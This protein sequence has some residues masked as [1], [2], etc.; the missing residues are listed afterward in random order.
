MTTTTLSHKHLAVNSF[1]AVWDL[2]DLP[3][4]TK[5]EEEKMIHLAHTSF[6]H[7][8][9]VEDHSAKN[10][11]IGYWQLSRVYAVAQLGERALYFGERCLEVSMKNEIE[12][13]YIGYAYEALCR[14]NAL[15]EKDEQ[16]KDQFNLAMEYAQ[17]V[18]V[19]SAKESLIKDL[20]F[21]FSI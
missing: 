12:P 18:K 16:A 14:A 10:L 7:W 2:L 17:L 5:E 9:Q 15:L 20:N 19:E 6:W 13:F 8:T 11:S 4:R 3:Q 21:I 1:N